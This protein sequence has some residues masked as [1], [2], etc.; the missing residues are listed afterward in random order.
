MGAR[1]CARASG[2]RTSMRGKKKQQYPPPPIQNAIPRIIFRPVVEKKC[3]IIPPFKTMRRNYIF[4]PFKIQP[5]PP[6][7]IF[8]QTELTEGKK[9]AIISFKTTE[10][11]R[12][13]F[14]IFR[15]TWRNRHLIKIPHPS[16][17]F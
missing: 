14:L 4:T 12:N 17:H 9:C 13:F 15:Q 16:P 10:G 2:A 3:I 7:I 8:K 5:A 6:P 11:K 1:A